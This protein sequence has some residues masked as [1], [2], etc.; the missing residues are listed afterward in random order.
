MH[1]RVDQ[2]RNEDTAG[3]LDATSR[4]ASRQSRVSDSNDLSLSDAYRR[5]E[6]GNRVEIRFPDACPDDQIF[7]HFQILT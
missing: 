5:R 2:P 7:F 3:E 4:V 6:R 1:V